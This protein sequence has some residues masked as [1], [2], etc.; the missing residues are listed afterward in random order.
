MSRPLDCPACERPSPSEF[1][2][3]HHDRIGGERYRLWRCL[4][5]RV[6]WSEPRRAVG[7]EWYEKAA[8][9]RVQEHRPD[10]SKDWRFQQFFHD[11]L[12][13]GA[14]LDVGCGDGGFL[15]LASQH[16]FKPVGFDYDARVVA[17][18]RERGLTEVHAAEFSSFC[19]S[20]KPGE[21]D[22]A[23]LF[24]V[25][26]HTPEPAWFFGQIK[27]L[28]KP[29]G[30]VALTMPNA[31]RPLPWGREEHDFPPHHFTHWTPS[32]LKGFLERQGFRV[33]RQEA[34]IL[35]TRYISENYFFNRVMPGPLNLARRSLFG[36]SAT[37]GATISELYSRPQS[38]NS[39]LADKSRRQKLVDVGRIAF[40]ALFAPAAL[41]LKAYYKARNPDC[42]DSLYT[43]ARLT[44]TI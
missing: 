19:L 16:G 20:R 32:A 7:A 1:I 41:G 35:K 23:V 39:W 38:R 11:R 29:G 24:D 2:E 26:E 25:L 18:A 28:L 6:V 13:P 44:E 10:P 22:A 33:V 3:E 12:P 31:L 42:G 30:H 14:I 40:N 36:K 27:K 21:F 15:E 9:I 43:L 17:R 5:C 34:G 8:P 37:S 4:D